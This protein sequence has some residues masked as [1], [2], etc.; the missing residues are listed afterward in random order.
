MIQNNVY[1]I[2]DS[3]IKKYYS[4]YLDANIDS[5]SLNSFILMSQGIRIQST[6]G[7]DLYTKYIN[8]I[9]TYQAPQGAQYVYLMDTYIQPATALWS[10]YEALPSLNF[11]MTNKALSTKSS[12]YGQPS[13]KND[14]EYIRQQVSNNAQFYSQRIREYITNYPFDFPEY[15]TTTGVN[16]IRAKQNQYF[17]GLYL[18]DVPRPKRVGAGWQQDGRCTGCPGGGNGYYLV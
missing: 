13:S 10:I 11:K 18:P 14:V 3:Y 6:L 2:T 7:F 12:E 5:D 15:Y 8:D 17:A 1:F 9:L 4:G 16:R